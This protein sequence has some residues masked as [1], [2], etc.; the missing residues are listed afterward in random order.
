LRSRCF[1]CIWKYPHLEQPLLIL[2]KYSL[3]YI[4]IFRLFE[5]LFFAMFSEINP[6][7]HLNQS[8]KG[9]CGGGEAARSV[10]IQPQQRSVRIELLF[11]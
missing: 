5:I 8:G 1:V 10:T 3:I 7:L 2:I 6:L 11:L 9:F 4:S